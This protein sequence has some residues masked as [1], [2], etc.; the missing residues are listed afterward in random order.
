M[1]FGIAL[2]V[3]MTMLVGGFAGQAA[4]RNQKAFNDAE[5][6]M[7]A[8]SGGMAEVALGKIVDAKARNADVKKFA[9]MMV[10]DH[11]K[12]NEQLKKAAKDAG[13]DVPDKMTEEDQ[14][15]V[16]RFKNYKGSNFDQDYMKQMVSDHEKDIAEFKRASKEARNPKIKD[17]AAKTLPI[18]QAHLDAAQK[19]QP[20]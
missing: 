6:V 1:S 18:L 17:F 15:L 7:K 4:P 3:T 10:N 14:K 5:F 2:N 16:D 20:K 8:A 9:E 19:I 12:A 13:V 11:S